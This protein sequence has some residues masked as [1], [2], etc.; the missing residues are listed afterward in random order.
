MGGDWR[1]IKGQVLGSSN[2]NKQIPRKLFVDSLSPSDSK[3]TEVS[4]SMSVDELGVDSASFPST[5]KAGEVN[6]SVLSPSHRKQ[7]HYLN[8]KLPG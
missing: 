1:N 7:V 4:T 8:D 5:S 6:E 3:S 2:S